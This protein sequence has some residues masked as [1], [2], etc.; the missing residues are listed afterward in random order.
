MNENLFLGG[1]LKK[2]QGGCDLG[3]DFFLRLERSDQT[4]KEAVLK[5]D[6]MLITCAS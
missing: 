5:V 6:Q 1:Y 4:S 3:G 2:R